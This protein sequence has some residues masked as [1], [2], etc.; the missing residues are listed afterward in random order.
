MNQTK[1]ADF[2]GRLLSTPERKDEIVHRMRDKFS[3]GNFGDLFRVCK[4][5]VGL[6]EW[7]GGCATQNPKNQHQNHDQPSCQDFRPA[8]GLHGP[9]VKH[10]V[11]QVQ[12]HFWNI[13]D[14]LF[15]C[16]VF[17]DLKV[18]EGVTG[19][20]GIR[21]FFGKNSLTQNRREKG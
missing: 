4:C 19:V 12:T 14:F 16:P 1:R 10:P 3:P 20:Q 11:F 7:P 2:T 13:P 15:C 9:K 5:K 6:S 8:L 17:Q 18:K 21:E